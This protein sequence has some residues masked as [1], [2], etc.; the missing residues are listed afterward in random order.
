MHPMMHT[1]AEISLTLASGTPTVASAAQPAEALTLWQAV[2]LGLV[3]GITEYLPVSSTGHLIL[4]SGLMGLENPKSKA[5][6]D[7]FNVIIQGGAILAVVGLYWK[8]VVQMLK[9]LVGKDNEGFNLAVCLLIAFVPAAAVGLVFKKMITTMLFHP[10]PV[11]AA[12]LVGGVFMIFIDLWHK[13]RFSLRPFHGTQGDVTSMTFDRALLIG[14]L[15]CVS[16]WPGTSRSMMTIT[17]GYIAGLKPKAAAEFSFLLGVI[18]LTAATGKELVGNIREA[19]Q[20]GSANFLQVLGVVPVVV[21]IVVAA[22]SAAIAVKFLVSFLTRYG[23]AW[24][25]VYRIV[26]AVVL[27]IL[28]MK[29]IVSIEK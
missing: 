15:Q 8:R 29:G 13:G 2:I 1:F 22:V 16:L 4:A 7:A 21:G 23:L 19:Q 6:I 28:V 3:E 11:L 17:G 5:A 18:T 24:F 20:A 10:T 9:G 25:G 12:L 26:L 27:G 14:V